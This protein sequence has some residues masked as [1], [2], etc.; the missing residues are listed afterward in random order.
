MNTKTNT[1]EYTV[2]KGKRYQMKNWDDSTDWCLVTELQGDIVE[3]KFDDAQI[4]TMSLKHFK[5]SL[6]ISN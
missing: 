2:S 5:A 3:V 6:V 4:Q 1:N